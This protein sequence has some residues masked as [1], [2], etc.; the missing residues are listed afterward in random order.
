MWTQSKALIPTNF[1]YSSTLF[2]L[3]F[4]KRYFSA[5]RNRPINCTAYKIRNW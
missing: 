4:M 1:R 3:F 2:I 5:L